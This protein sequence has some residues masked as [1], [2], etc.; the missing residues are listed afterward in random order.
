MFILDL[1]VYLLSY[2]KAETITAQKGSLTFTTRVSQR[3]LRDGPRPWEG[4]GRRHDHG[5]RL[6]NVF[7]ITELMRLREGKDSARWFPSWLL[8]PRQSPAR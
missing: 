5:A 4:V 1:S 8:I 7:N 3:C 6:E 2:L